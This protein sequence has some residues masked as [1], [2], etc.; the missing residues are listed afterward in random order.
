MQVD[1][2]QTEFHDK[3]GNHIV[4]VGVATG[5]TSYTT[6]GDTSLPAGTANLEALFGTAPGRVDC[7]L[8]TPFSNGTNIYLAVYVPGTGGAS[9]KVQFFDPSSKAEVSAATNLSGFTARF[10]AFVR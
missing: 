9:G 1:R 6:G 8:F 3:T 5:P 4:T 10:I 7:I 2:T